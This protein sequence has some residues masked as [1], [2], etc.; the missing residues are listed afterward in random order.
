VVDVI[1]LISCKS[2][3]IDFV[4]DLDDDA[5]DD[6]ENI[7]K[8]SPDE[9]Q[10]RLQSSEKGNSYVL[11][12]TRID[13]QYRSDVLEKLCLYDFVSALYKKKINAADKNYLSEVIQSTER[14]DNRRGRPVGKRYTFQKEH[15]QATTYLL[16]EHSEPQVPVLFG[17]QIPRKDR[18]NTRER[19]CRALLTLFLP[20]RT[21]RDLC[22]VDQTWE[23]AFRSRQSLIAA[24]SWKIIDNIQLLHECKKDRD[25]HLLQVIAEAQAENDA[26]DP[27][28]LPENP[29][30]QEE[31]DME[32]PEYLLELL[33]QLDERTL[34]AASAKDSSEG[35]YIQE[36]ILAVERVGRFAEKTSEHL[37]INSESKNMIENSFSVE[38]SSAHSAI[39]S[40]STEI[41]PFIPA[42]SKL[43]RL[44]A[45]WKEQLKSERDRVRRSL[46]TGSHAQD[47]GPLSFDAV[48]DAVVTVI[49]SGPTDSEEM[50]YFGHMPP[51]VSIT[52]QFP[53][54]QTVADEFTLNREQRAA[55]MIITSHLDGDA[56]CRSG[57]SILERSDNRQLMFLLR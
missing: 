20:W 25:E 5:I 32:D 44:N 30:S 50:D 7:D 16:M 38:G 21:V 52:T 51:L 47:N 18:D 26:V 3:A 49:S 36:T 54:Q 15:P 55:F 42:N 8:E 43:L 39:Y 11:V 17:P 24:H 22:N 31:G 56:R 13:Y 46:I 10:F 4:A 23:D 35:R 28:L 48:K 2:K 19:Y 6:D 33:G 45:T 41:S 9:E 14:T 57:R 53:S 37:P 12:N 34:L 27:E 29:T 40:T 1:S